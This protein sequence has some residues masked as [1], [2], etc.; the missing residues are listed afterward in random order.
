MLST[1]INILA[2]IGGRNAPD[3]NPKEVE[4]D[5]YDLILRGEETLASLMKRSGT[6]PNDLFL[7]LDYPIFRTQEEAER[8]ADG[9]DKS[10]IPLRDGTNFENRA[11]LQEL[12]IKH[13]EREGFITAELKGYDKKPIV[14]RKGTE[15]QTKKG[16]TARFSSAF[17]I[18]DVTYRKFYSGRVRN[19]RGN[20]DYFIYRLGLRIF[21][22]RN[23]KIQTVSAGYLKRHYRAI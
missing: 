6:E 1:I 4:L 20:P 5:E 19:A 2:A 23:R 12:N 15:L 14:L 16:E 18:S 7:F 17:F 10:V 9:T 8:C 21:I 3:Q 11:A 13:V 22:E